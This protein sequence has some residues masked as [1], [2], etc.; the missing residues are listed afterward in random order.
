[1]SNDNL[2]W[3]PVQQDENLGIAYRKFIAEY[4]GLGHM[5]NAQEPGL[6]VIPHYAV[7][8]QGA[9]PCKLNCVSCLMRLLVMIQVSI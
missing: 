8:K 9:N 6:N 7:W 3:S 5:T 2:V 4:K 1:M